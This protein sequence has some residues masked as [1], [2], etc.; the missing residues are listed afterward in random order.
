MPLN[1][2][3]DVQHNIIGN[4]YFKVMAIH[5]VAGRGFGPQDTATSQRVAIISEHVARVL[6]PAGSPIGRTYSIGDPDAMEKPQQVQVVGIV[7]DVKVHGVVARDPYIDY[8]PYSQSP[9]GFGNF[10]V[11]YTGQFGAVAREVQQAIHAINPNLPISNVSTLDVQ[12]ARSF[13]NQA[14]IAELSAFFGVV[15]VFLSCIGLYGLMSYLVGRRTG[16][17]GIRMALGARRPEVA[18][19]IM[20]EIGLW[21]LAGIALGIPVTLAGGR[22][23]QKMLYGLTGTDLSSL[24]AAIGILIIAGLFAGYLPA[25]RAARVDPAVALRDE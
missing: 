22:L 14:I 19:R 23:V 24:L 13:A 21:I 1:R 12:V 17:I 16:E 2:D 25:R 11:R 4:A 10:Q 3:A 18:W 6:F 5:L 9:W 7:K 20:R 8:L 15:A